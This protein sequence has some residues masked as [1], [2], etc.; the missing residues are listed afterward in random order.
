MLYHLAVPRIDSVR[1]FFDAASDTEALGCYAWCQTVAAGLFPILGDF[2]VGLRNALHRALSQYYGGVDSHNWLIPQSIAGQDERR[3]S[4][5]S[6]GQRT[7]N[8]VV[9]I[10]DKIARRKGSVNQ[11]DIVAALSFGFWEQIVSS[12]DY[13]THPADLQERILSAVFPHAP[14]IDAFPYRSVNFKQRAVRLLSQVRDVR[15]RIGHHDA[16]WSVHEFDEYGKKGFV[17]R[18]PHHACASIEKFAQRTAWFAGWIDP[19]IT[20]HIRTSD[21]WSR[22]HVLLTDGALRLYKS[23]GGQHGTYEAILKAS[24]GTTRVHSTAHTRSLR[25]V[26]I[27]P[28]F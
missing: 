17:P 9:T 15:N 20:R 2:E 24:S 22:L 19:V 16:I 6:L 11:D 28:C 8:D 13:R 5:H 26:E 27:P 12:I 21:H 25:A 23:T 18:K 3:K 4:T 14:D 10:A 1:I 7:R